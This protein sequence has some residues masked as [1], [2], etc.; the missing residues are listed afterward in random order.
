MADASGLFLG[1]MN[2]EN[3]L[4]PAAQTIAADTVKST[5]KSAFSGDGDE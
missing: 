4:A 2:K 1:G 5:M 3:R